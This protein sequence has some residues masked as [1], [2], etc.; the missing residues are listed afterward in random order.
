MW[1]GIQFRMFFFSIA[2]WGELEVWGR[3]LFIHF[4]FCVEGELKITDFGYFV[5]IW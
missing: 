5:L 3:R 4:V 2:G 1:G